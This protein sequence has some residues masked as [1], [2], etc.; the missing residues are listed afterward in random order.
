MNKQNYRNTQIEIS[1]ERL[2]YILLT[3]LLVLL[4]QCKKAFDNMDLRAWNLALITIDAVDPKSLGCY[5]GKKETA[6]FLD[7]LVK[8]RLLVE[9][10]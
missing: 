2:I 7:S 1:K 8:Q 4:A 10:A 9:Y 3:L 5:G 6:K